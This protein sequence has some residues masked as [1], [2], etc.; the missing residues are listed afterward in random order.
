MIR[1]IVHFPGGHSRVARRAEFIGPWLAMVKLPNA[2][3]YHLK[4]HDPTHTREVVQVTPP[5]C[6]VWRMTSNLQDVLDAAP[7]CAVYG[8]TYDECLGQLD[9]IYET[10]EGWARVAR[11]HGTY[12]NE[13]GHSRHDV[14]H[15]FER[16]VTQADNRYDPIEALVHPKAYVLPEDA[17]LLG[18]DNWYGGKPLAEHKGRAILED[19]LQAAQAH[20][21]AMPMFPNGAAARVVTAL[22]VRTDEGQPGA[23]LAACQSGSSGHDSMDFAG[24][25][26][27][28]VTVRYDAR[29]ND[30]REQRAESRRKKQAA[31]D[32]ADRRLRVVARA[33]DAFYRTVVYSLGERSVPQLR[34]AFENGFG[35]PAA[36][37]VGTISRNH[38]GD[39]LAAALELHRQLFGD[40]DHVEWKTYR[41]AHAALDEAKLDD[42]ERQTVGV[43]VALVHAMDGRGLRPRRVTAGPKRM[44]CQACMSR[45]PYDPRRV[46]RPWGNHTRPTP[47]PVVGLCRYCGSGRLVEVPEPEP[48][49][50][51]EDKGE[52]AALVAQAASSAAASSPA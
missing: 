17:K 35:H 28:C 18:D 36:S 8:E 7:G 2:K 27:W 47:E 44:T 48:E 33:L 25:K 5:G 34:V 4:S 21:G 22:R 23:Y 41:A 40:N 13:D 29:M 14:F 24:G 45:Q 31:V 39:R 10:P 16:S 38:A 52:D 30:R 49:A 43:S 9:R 50:T 51:V 26:P 11:L 42:R 1:H 6:D 19:V 3:T 46:T 20:G 37:E 32:A 12:R 15:A